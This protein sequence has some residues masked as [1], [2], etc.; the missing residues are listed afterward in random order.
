MY[1]APDV[2]VIPLPEGDSVLY[3][4]LLGIAAQVNPQM[5]QVIEALKQA[6]PGSQTVEDPE[7]RQQLVELGLLRESPY[8]PL[9]PDSRRDAFDVTS[10]SLFLT[11]ACNLGC[12]YC[13]ASANEAPASLPWPVAKS[14]VDF[15]FAN[16][17]RTGKKRAGLVLHG[18]GEPTLTWELLQRIVH[19]ARSISAEQ[20]VPTAISIGTNGVM[21]PA[22]AE[23][24][25]RHLDSATV[26]LDG[27][28]DVH[29]KN[30]PTVG[31]GASYDVVL[32]TLKTFDELGLAYGLRMTVTE[33][34][35]HRLPEAIER[36]CELT[37]VKTI[38][39][40]PVF[41]VG[42]AERNGLGSPS[43]RAFVTAFRKANLLAR[44]LGRRLTYSGARLGQVTDRFCEAPGRSFAVTP[45]GHVSSCYEVSDAADRRYD[46][47]FWGEFDRDQ[48]RFVLD[49]ERR[50]AQTQMTVHGKAG[51]SD[52]FCKWHCAGDCSAKLAH[53]GDPL[54][55]SANPRCEVNRLLTRDQLVRA[56]RNGEGLG[57]TSYQQ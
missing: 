26:S 2:F 41:S 18:G 50:K 49:E 55:T 4:P 22:R 10:A 34:W 8:P 32:G 45:S 21:P 44:N 11:S 47:F 14:A 19:Y 56:I 42:R 36:I 43:A 12:T 37:K 15:V 24:L 46:T 9:A 20:D 51:C 31:G 1:L 17:K 48:Q 35:V 39:A 5:A 13:Y 7:V 52:C 29:N 3:A 53:L 6:L 28:P 16:V 23:W 38:Q 27:P 30:R 54:D 40:E 33:D 57:R 25:A